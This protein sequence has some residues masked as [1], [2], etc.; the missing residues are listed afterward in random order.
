MERNNV[1]LYSTNHESSFLAF[2]SE[3]NKQPVENAILKK[4]NEIL[5]W[6]KKDRIKFRFFDRLFYAVICKLSEKAKGFVILIQPNTV[7]RWQIWN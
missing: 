6:K 4:E 2:F 5:K 3:T 1:L 7:L